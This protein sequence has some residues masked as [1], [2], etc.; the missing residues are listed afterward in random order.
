MKT[1]KLLAIFLLLLF[2]QNIYS[3]TDSRNRTKE[4]IV[5]DCLAQLPAKNL[6]S[7]NQVSS[8][9]A[10]TGKEGMEMLV[11]M[12]LPADQA[13]NATFEYAI[14]GVV[15]YVS[16]QKNSSLRAGVQQGLMSGFVKCSDKVNRAF[17][18]SEMAKIATADD[19]AFFVDLLSDADLKNAAVS[20]LASI[21]GTDNVISSLIKNNTAPK[22]ELAY[23]AYMKKLRGVEDNLLSW[24]N[25]ADEKTLTSIYNAL[26]VCGSEKSVKTLETA[27]K[28]KNFENDPTGATDAYLQLLNNYENNTVVLAA[29]KSLLKCNRP[30][31]RC[32]GLTL[33]LKKDKPN[34]AKNILVSLK[35]DCAQ[36]RNTALGLAK[37]VAGE[38]IFSTVVAKRAGNSATID[39]VRWLGNNKRTDQLDY[40]VKVMRQHSDSTLTRAAIEAAGKI[41]GET[42]LTALIGELSGKY[43]PDA[44]NALLA[45]NG[46][47]N[48]G[49]SKALVS[50]DKNIVKHALEIASTRHIYN[51]YSTVLG[52]TNSSD[53]DIKKC[54][55]KSLSGVSAT[56]HF[57]ELCKLMESTSDT[58]IIG[59]LQSATKNAIKP[60]S[61]EEQYNLADKH[62]AKTTRPSLY[63]P[64]LAQVGNKNAV[65]KLKSEYINGNARE[66]AYKSLLQVDNIVVADVLYNIG[67]D[68]DA[69][70]DEAL[71]RYLTLIR[72]SR[73]NYMAKYLLY[74]KALDLNPASDVVKRNALDYLA[75]CPC[76]PAMVLA[77]KYLDK[78]ATALKAATTVK[79]IAAKTKSLQGGIMVKSI[80]NKAL[81]VFKA[82]TNNA[83]AG[84]AVDEINGQILPKFVNEGY[85]EVKPVVDAEKIILGDKVYENFELYLEW[86][87]TGDA[88]LDLRSMPQ[89]MLGKDIISVNASQ[90]TAQVNTIGWNALAIKVVNDRLS[91]ESNGVT[92][93]DNFIMK[94]TP[95]TAALLN[96][97][98]L[99][100]LKKNGNFDIRDVYVKELPSTPIY[101]LTPDEAKAGFEALFDGR[102]LD[103]WQ[104]NL[105]DY[106]PLDGNIYVSAKY[107]GT[108]NLYTKKKYSDFIYRFDFCFDEPGV[109]NGIGIRTNIGTDA[110]YDGME[111]QVLDH[112]D[113]IYKGLHDYQRHGSVYGIIVPKHIIF[114]KV[115]T[116]YSEEIRAV[117]DHITVTVNGDVV[118][119]GNIREACQGH[120]VAPDGGKTNPY[121]VDHKNHP[122]LFNK[123]GY[124][125]FCGHG[126]G[127]KF[128]NVRILDLSKSKKK[129]R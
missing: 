87:S 53:A 122:G 36:Y 69:K 66:A 19:A 5:Q 45:Y 51:T 91:V 121:T 80:L 103:K 41:G 89:V 96:E 55:Y 90:A 17:L 119:D 46:K 101:K 39:I 20:A 56:G 105:T 118:L 120:N 28:L 62:I 48:E 115:G 6:K 29:A 82:Q 1:I 127:V 4:T 15:S 78:E 52:L 93:I 13:K 30:A 25:G 16:S 70:K 123:D 116:W 64:L 126:V 107:G 37:E 42:A 57:E 33:L 26:T 40:V 24:T 112:D 58:K 75:D 106:V 94:N 21:K 44:K 110:A 72:K 97:G 74:K 102:N 117:G 67:K 88:V 12:M 104:G 54:A 95:E 129:K 65:N 79:T 11:G 49:I 18:V 100:V 63:Y 14:D 83:D 99:D 2:V 35:D 84:Y 50:S 113:P 92:L 76:L 73:N 60:L 59:Y 7:L 27:A 111:I 43:A 32:A 68:D 128:R 9:I 125:S 47:I 85:A 31:V 3:Q 34:A 8:E 98:F 109:N 86:K 61:A 23:L 10:A 81:D 22:A 71:G 108:G 124:I 77:S 38:D 114:D